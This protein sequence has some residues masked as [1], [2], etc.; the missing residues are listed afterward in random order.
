MVGR[1][2]LNIHS[3][4]VLSGSGTDHIYL[5]TDLP[6]GCYPYKRFQTI[7]LEVASGAGIEYA[8]KYLGIEPEL[9]DTRS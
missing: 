8:R 1:I 9:V 4:Q 2:T 7:K 6:D 5:I 3:A